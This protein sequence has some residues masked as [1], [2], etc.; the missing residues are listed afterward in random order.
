MNPWLAAGGSASLFALSA[1]LLSAER[2]LLGLD[3]GDLKALS[4]THPRASG[5]LELM[6][7]HAASTL[8]SFWIATG[9]LHAASGVCLLPLLR[10]PYGWAVGTAWGLVSATLLTICLHAAPAFALETRA[11][12]FA[13]RVA[14]PAFVLV[15]LLAPL[16]APLHRTV[17]WLLRVV[18]VAKP[19]VLTEEEILTGVEIGGD[20][21]VLHVEESGMVEGILGLEGTQASEVMTPRVDLVGVPIDA[22]TS[23]WLRI[24]RSVRFRHL[25]V[26][27]ES[28]DTIVGMLDVVRFLL[29][30]DHDRGAA[31]SAPH[32]VPETA[33]LDGLLVTLQR[34]RVRCAVVLDEYGGTAGVIT[35][36]DILEEISA[37]VTGEYAPETPQIE[38]T[39]DGAWVVDGTVSLDDLNDELGLSLSSDG[40]DRIAGWVFDHGGRLPRIGER[41]D[42][43]G[44][45]A[46]V[47]RLR[48]HRILQVQLERLEHGSRGGDAT[49]G[50]GGDA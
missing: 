12:R 49:S 15:R 20:Q 14:T 41:V 24:A 21:G 50:D 29:D 30:P 33:S 46:T 40:S 35:R 26:Y 43:Q 31:V 9:L 6:R 16:G 28:I 11:V 18:G 23:D 25:P 17:A 5:R 42:A 8:A 45:R 13:G 34:Q 47:L 39:G 27:R 19:R 32:C 37:D 7:Q 48:K 22:P 1:L 44:C 38:A 36:G 2:L 10:R 3:A 4:A